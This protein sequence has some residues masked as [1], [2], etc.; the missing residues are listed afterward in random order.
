[1][2]TGYSDW[3]NI[4]KSGESSGAPLP[5]CDISGRSSETCMTPTTT[6]THLTPRRFSSRQKMSARISEEYGSE[7]REC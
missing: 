3:R 1:M 2:S 6:N 7:A 4:V 5:R